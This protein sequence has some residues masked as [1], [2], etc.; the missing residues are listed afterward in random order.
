MSL[1]A[2]CARGD[3]FFT[4]FTFCVRGGECSVK[5]LGFPS[6]AV[7]GVLLTVTGVLVCLGGEGM[8]G[9]VDGSRLPRSEGP[10]LL[11]GVCVGWGEGERLARSF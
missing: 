3:C 8:A 7:G 4:G 10:V 6:A 9:S 2:D 1:A 5:G 11:P